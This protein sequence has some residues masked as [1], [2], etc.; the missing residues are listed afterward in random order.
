VAL[1]VIHPH[2]ASD[3]SFRVKFIREAKTAAKV[4][5]THL[6]NV[7]DQTTDGSLLF[8]VMEYVPGITLRDALQRFGAIQ[9]ERALE[10]YLPMLEGLAAAHQAGIL[11]RDIKPDNFLYDP[12]THTGK[13]IDFGNSDI[14]I[15]E[16][17]K[18][19]KL[20]LNKDIKRIVE[21][22]C[23]KEGRRNTCSVS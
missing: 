1:K 2:L 3:P 11:H 14:E 23:N 13:L 6:V 5:H 18:P 9:I 12:E 16:N 8:L 10:V 22:Q 17:R 20:K 21:I 15:D 19:I 7:Y 4:S